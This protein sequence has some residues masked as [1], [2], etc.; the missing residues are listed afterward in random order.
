MIIYNIF[1]IS[2]SKD[3]RFYGLLKTIG[4][5]NRQLKKLVRRQALLLGLVGTPIGLILGYVVSFFVT[6]VV[7]STT[8]MANEQLVSVN[9]LI[10]I[11]GGLFTL[12]TVWISCIKPWPPCE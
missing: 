1:Y 4:T 3:I 7:M 9:P 2:I 12:I 5:T 6:P 11:G 8:S 10:F